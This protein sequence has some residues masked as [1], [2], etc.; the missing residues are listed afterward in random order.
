MANK[1]VKNRK[2]TTVQSPK[3]RGFALEAPELAIW[4]GVLALLRE[5][6]AKQAEIND[7]AGSLN[8][9]IEGRIGRDDVVM[10]GNAPTHRVDPE[11]LQVRPLTD[12]ERMELGIFR[13]P[14]PEE[15]DNPKPEE[16]DNPD[17]K[18]DDGGGGGGHA[19]KKR[20][21]GS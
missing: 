16:S 11:T 2:A 12:R 19:A 21:G 18:P 5:R 14:P 3:V 17:S 8:R 10:G 1:I 7:L 6:E 13:P 9:I 20:R 4:K 15:S